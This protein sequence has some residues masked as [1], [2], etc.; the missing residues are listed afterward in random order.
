MLHVAKDG[1]S[2]ADALWVAVDTDRDGK[3]GQ[4]NGSIQ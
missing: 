1:Q 4:S 3:V 2:A